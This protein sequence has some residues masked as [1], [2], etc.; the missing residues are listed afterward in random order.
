MCCFACKREEF[1]YEGV[2]SDDDEGA[3]DDEDDENAEGN[4]RNDYPD[5]DPGYLDPSH[6]ASNYFCDDDG[7]TASFN[8]SNL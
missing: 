6:H 4:W 2:G 1:V 3:V 7:L 8:S 5:E